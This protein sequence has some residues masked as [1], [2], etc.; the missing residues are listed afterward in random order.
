MSLCNEEIASR[1]GDWVTIHGVKSLQTLS[2]HD[3]NA[4]AWEKKNLEPQIETQVAESNVDL[5]RLALLAP[6]E[7]GL[8]TNHLHFWA[9]D[10]LSHPP[11]SRNDGASQPKNI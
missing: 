8:E 11:A 10:H 3:T 7:S 1:D 9:R 4:P 6:G 2:Q 5:L